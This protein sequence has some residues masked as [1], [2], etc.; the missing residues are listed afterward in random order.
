VSN[1]AKLAEYATKQP[2]TG[3]TRLRIKIFRKGYV[4]KFKD[5]NAYRLTQRVSIQVEETYQHSYVYVDSGGWVTT[6]I[7]VDTIKP[8][9]YFWQR[10]FRRKPKLPVAR[11]V[12]DKVK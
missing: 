3:D 9:P 2:K 12:N 4:L 1:E 6:T 7:F 11:I 8:A 5:L 10:L